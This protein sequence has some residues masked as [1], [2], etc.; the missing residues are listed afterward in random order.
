MDSLG[1]G[2]LHVTAGKSSSS[3][4]HPGGY[5]ARVPKGAVVLTRAGVGPG[6]P[7]VED[8]PE[9]LQ[10][11]AR[12]VRRPRRPG[13]A[14]PDDA[15]A[16]APAAACGRAAA[17]RRLRSTDSLVPPPPG[18]TRA[19]ALALDAPA[20]DAYWTHIHRILFRKVIS[21]SARHRS[22]TGTRLR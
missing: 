7:Y 20:L 19:A 14:R 5:A 15:I 11:R 4:P 2:R 6:M 18:I 9:A 13:A 8:A 16:V 3:P 1:N 17:W 21:G 12:G 10:R 22:R